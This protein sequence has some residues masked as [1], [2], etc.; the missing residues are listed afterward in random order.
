[1]KNRFPLKNCTSN[2]FQ[3]W[4][5]SFLIFSAFISFS[6]QVIAQCT[7]APPA[8]VPLG[9][10]LNGLADYVRDRAFN[11]VFKTSR[12]MSGNITQPFNFVAIPLDAKGWPLKDFGVVVMTEMDSTMGGT[13]KIQFNGQATI[14]A[15]SGSNFTVA[16]K[17]YNS[18]TNTTTADLVYPAIISNG[19]SMFIGFTN[20]AFS[21]T[22]KGVKNIKI[23]KPG[24]AFNG[25]TFSQRFLTHLARFDCIR[26]MDWHSTNGNNDS[27]WAKRTLKT[28]PS[29]QKLNGVAWEYVIE[30]ANTLQKDVWINVPHKV[31][32]PYVKNLATLFR[33]SLNP[34][35]HIYVEYSNEVWNGQFE[36]TQYVNEHSFIDGNIAGSDINFDNVNDPFTWRMR[37]VAKRSKEISDIF[38]ST[39][40]AAAINN[41]VRV[42]LGQQFGFFDFTVRGV[43][44][45]NAFYGKPG[46]YFYALATA[47]YFN[48]AELDARN[49]AAT[50]AQVLDELDLQMN[51]DFPEFNNAMDMW[52]ARAAFYGLQM[53]AYEGG[54]D[55][56][57]PNNVQS[58]I[59]AS[60][61]PRMR[62][63]CE[64]YLNKWYKYGFVGL[65]NWFSAGAAN[66]DGPF[67]SWAVT[68]N[69]E[70][71]QK[72]QAL[73]S[74]HNAAV[75]VFSAGQQAPGVV[76]PRKFAGY[77]AAQLA[78]SFFRPDI[79]FH[80]FF[81][82]LVNVPAGQDGRY[83]ITIG[84][85]ANSNGQTFKM[86]V[87]NN[88]GTI[89]T[90]VNNG[91][92]TFVNVS[93][94]NFNLKQGF[95][96]IRITPVGGRN[97]RL[98]AITFTRTG[99]CLGVLNDPEISSSQYQQNFVI[100][101]NPASS[102]IRIQFN[103]GQIAK[104]IKILS[105]DGNLIK[106]FT[107]LNGSYTK[108]I[109]LPV[110]DIASGFHML[111]IEYVDGTS[112]KNN[113]VV[114]R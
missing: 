19:S 83:K 21:A 95:H 64:N 37:Y 73:D 53:V 63:I 85:C 13:Y 100:F 98:N 82:Y 79:G 75:P 89:F 72:L 86:Q 29:Q 70:N 74:V 6:L 22:I 99:T 35:L 11:D 57:G 102:S 16:N 106:L 26:Y 31:N 96:T 92:S 107:G 65:F 111:V 15:V 61:N 90:P 114:Q 46:T 80:E 2:F 62:F 3:L 59:S 93:A 69:F 42:V 81:E 84:A 97:F 68:E 36:Q 109:S 103:Q 20:T 5:K 91:F 32:D 104:K 60:R 30:M 24:I 112:S 27:L 49:P 18:S 76:D 78:N 14:Q 44:F 45:I 55:T 108:Y 48:T 34:A 51:N 43:D 56:F 67:G 23:M 47:P 113:F 110:N 41:R 52:A 12:D 94:K 54:P 40:G 17:V 101:P 58:K 7:L 66:Y 71:S 33:D 9:A 4:A 88:V 39:F 8:K 50:S 10:N 38:K 105:A 25:P 1:M 77:D 28:A 87:D